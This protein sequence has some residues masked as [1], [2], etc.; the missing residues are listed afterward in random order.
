MPDINKK[1]NIEVEDEREIFES[2]LSAI[3]PFLI[4]ETQ[5]SVELEIYSGVEKAAKEYLSLYKGKYFSDSALK[6]LDGALASYL[7]EKGYYRGR[8]KYR[9][10]YS[11]CARSPEQIDQSLILPSST[12]LTN[13]G[14]KNKTHFY[15]NELLEKK[16]PSFVTITENEIVSI[17]SVNEFSEGQHILEIT[18]ETA[19]EYRRN[20]YST[21]NTAALALYVL[22]QGYSVA[23]CCSRYNITSKRIAQA[24]GFS[25]DGRFYAVDAYKN[26]DN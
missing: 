11:L 24:V 25:I 1:I 23:Y 5:D 2:G 18:T 10:Y 13:N 21:S 16:L 22:K 26:S 14:Y 12:I 20:G 17:A 6:W 8:S 19:S 9:W 4:N 3:V 15:I 7:S